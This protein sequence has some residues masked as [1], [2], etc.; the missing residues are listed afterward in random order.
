MAV[1]VIKRNQAK[2]EELHNFIPS[3]HMPPTDNDL[4]N[5]MK[6]DLH[7]LMK[8][9]NR[10]MNMT[11]EQKKAYQGFIKEKTIMAGELPDNLDNKLDRYFD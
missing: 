6:I 1:G 10:E 8:A 4:L 2:L 7:I 9:M 5:P 11:K 3:E